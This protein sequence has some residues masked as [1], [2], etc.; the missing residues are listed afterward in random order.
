M[1][2]SV[3]IKDQDVL[4]GITWARIRANQPDITDQEFVQALMLSMLEGYAAQKVR[5]DGETKMLA[6]VAALTAKFEAARGK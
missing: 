2:F 1:E 3:T 4:D 5:V 6:D